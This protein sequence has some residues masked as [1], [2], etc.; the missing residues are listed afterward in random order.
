MTFLVPRMLALTR[1][2][3]KGLRV[4]ALVWLATIPHAHIQLLIEVTVE[5]PAIPAHVDCVSAHH[6]ICSCHIEPLH[7]HLQAKPI[8]VHHS[9]TNP[10]A[11]AAGTILLSRQIARQWSRDSRLLR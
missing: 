3:R 2:F 1:S 7:Q 4:G 5:Y 11:R 6:T 9:L 10:S 8:S